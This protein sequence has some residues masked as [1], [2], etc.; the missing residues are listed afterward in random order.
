MPSVALPRELDATEAARLPV[1]AASL[2]HC[3]SDAVQSASKNTRACF[4]ALGLLVARV[5]QLTAQRS[6]VYG[7]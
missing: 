1:F 2:G 5:Q 4:H 7:R 3:A 6:S